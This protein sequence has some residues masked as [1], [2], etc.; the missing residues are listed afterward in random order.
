MLKLLK[1]KT[2]QLCNG[3]ADWQSDGAGYDLVKI[4]SS[5]KSLLSPPRHA[6]AERMLSEGDEEAGER[7]VA[8]S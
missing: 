2:I 4:T 5:E 8:W 7:S 3:S 1:R 6:I